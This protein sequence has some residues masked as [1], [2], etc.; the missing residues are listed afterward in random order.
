MLAILNVMSGS[1]GHENEGKRMEANHMVGGRE[2]V[3]C[4]AFHGGTL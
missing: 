3:R 2:K 4:T 1:E